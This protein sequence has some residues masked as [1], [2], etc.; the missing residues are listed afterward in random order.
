MIRHYNRVVSE[1][2]DNV[3]DF[4]ILHYLCSGREDT[5]FWRAVKRDAEVPES[6]QERLGVWREVLPR[7]GNTPTAFHAFLPFSYAAVLAGLGYA[8]ETCP[9]ALRARDDLPGRSLL[10]NQA[11]RAQILCEELPSHVDYLRHLYGR[12]Q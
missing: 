6:L 4:I 10:R 3:R 8:P 1:C 9:P 7:V 5:P 12:E 11:E 2:F